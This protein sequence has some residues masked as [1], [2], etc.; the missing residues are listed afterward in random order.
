MFQAVTPND[1]V[2]LNF[3]TRAIYVGGAGNVA[4]RNALGV[5]VT[6]VAPPV[7]SFIPVVTDRV[8][9]TGTTATNLIALY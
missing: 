5:S 7:G 9:A 2:D 6:F 4:C 3:K 8:M 1:G